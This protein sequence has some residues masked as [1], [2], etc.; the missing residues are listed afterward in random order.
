MN[1]RI[2]SAHLAQSGSSGGSSFLVSSLKKYMTKMPANAE[3]SNDLDQ[4]QQIIVE[5]EQSAQ[6][7]GGKRPEEM[8]PQEM[9]SRLWAILSLRDKSAFKIPYIG[10]TKFQASQQLSSPSIEQLVSYQSGIEDAIL[11]VFR[12]S[13]RFTTAVG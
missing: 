10:E 7:N 12:A 8:T 5:N 1:N 3:L 13:P 4:M 6:G 11:T 2:H 9:H